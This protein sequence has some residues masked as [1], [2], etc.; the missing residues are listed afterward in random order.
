MRQTNPFRR[1][2][3]QPS[4]YTWCGSV[5][6]SLKSATILS[7]SRCR[8]DNAKAPREA[9]HSCQRRD[10]ST[11]YR[12]PN[13]HELDK[14]DA[15]VN[16]YRFFFFFLIYATNTS[17]RNHLFFF[18]FFATKSKTCSYCCLTRVWLTKLV[19]SFSKGSKKRQDEQLS[20]FSYFS[21]LNCLLYPYSILFR[22]LIFN[23]NHFCQRW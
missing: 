7:R 19:W 4:S 10:R 23:F 2:I 21:F 15:V 12:S 14:T 1:E 9:P 18:F 8:D 6:G 16:Q 22:L 11:Q 5:W 20:S 3:S 13:R 17:L